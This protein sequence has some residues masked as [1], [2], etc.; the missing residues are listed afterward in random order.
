LV[1]VSRIN[2]F[3]LSSIIFEIMQ[4]IFSPPDNTSTPAGAGLCSVLCF[5]KNKNNVLHVQKI[6]QNAHLFVQNIIKFAQVHIQ[7]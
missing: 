3:G 1:G 6:N 4:R 2:A 7:K 5:A